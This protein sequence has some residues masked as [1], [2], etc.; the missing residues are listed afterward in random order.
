M[1]KPF[2]M[3]WTIEERDCNQVLRDFLVEKKI[4]KSALTDIK[5]KGGYIY[6]NDQEVT[7]RHLL[8]NGDRVNIIFPKEEGSEQLKGEKLPLSIV[9]EDDY[10]MVVEKPAG[11]STIPSREHPTGS[12]AN[13]IIGHY[14]QIGH[15]ATVHI[16]TRL[17]RDTSGLVLIAKHRHVHHLLSLSK[18]NKTVER[19][20]KALTT[21]TLIPPTGLVEKPIGRMQNSII[22]REVR[23]DGQYACTEYQTLQ[24]FD[25]FS[26]V[27]LK[28]HTGRTHQIRVHMAHVGH[29]L[30][31]DDLYGGSRQLI[32]RQALHCY[33]LR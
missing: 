9:C 12:L 8:K 16:V 11:M 24:S 5:Y 28:L 4:S 25:T 33:S 13:A 31:G 19:K 32:E 29:P 15:E 10:V 26:L 27:E 20:Y 18:S 30:L 1:G 2:S 3:E 7:V 21:G 6:V 14:E 22:K 23:E 17:D